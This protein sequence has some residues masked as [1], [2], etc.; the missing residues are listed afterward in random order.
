[1]SLRV[2]HELSCLGRD[3]MP[4]SGLARLVECNF[5]VIGCVH[6]LLGLALE[7]QIAPL[8]LAHGIRGF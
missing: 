8:N 2:F 4:E 6:Q 1:M 5:V 7:M 3:W